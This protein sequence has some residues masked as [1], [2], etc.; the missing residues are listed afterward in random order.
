MSLVLLGDGRY[1]EQVADVAAALTDG[2][3]GQL[4]V[5]SDRWGDEDALT[6]RDDIKRVESLI[7]AVHLGL[8][9]GALESPAAR[10]QIVEHAV[11]EGAEV[12][13]ALVHPDAR[14]GA[15]VELGAGS[16]V[17][18]GAS[19]GSGVRV[20]DHAHIGLD[21]FVGDESVVG[22][23]ATVGAG[24]S[25]GRGVGIDEGATIGATVTVL[26]GVIIG[27]GAIV[28]DGAVVTADVAPASTVGR[29]VPLR[30]ARPQVGATVGVGLTRRRMGRLRSKRRVMVF[31]QFALPR[32]AP[33]G[34]RHVELFERLT[35]WEATIIAG[36]KSLLE[37]AP[38]VAEGSLRTVAV[39]RYRG[40]GLSRI[41]NWASYSAQAVWRGLTCRRPHVVYGSSPHLGAALAGLIVARARRAKF[42]LEVRDLWPQILVDAGMMKET[43][44]LYRLLKQLERFLYRHADGVVVLAR[45][46]VDAVIAEGADPQRVFFVPNGADPEDF[47][48]SEWREDLRDEFAF[49]GTVVVYAGAHGPANGLDLVLD[50]AEKLTDTDVEFVLVGDGVSKADLQA[51][52]QRRGITNVRF[53]DPIPKSEI[54]RL[55]AAA[56]VGLHCLADVALFHHGVS[57]N[58]LYDYMAAG[59]PV[60]TNTPGEV[61]S[62]VIEADSG[63]AVGPRELADG[64]RRLADLSPSVRAKLGR[65]GRE[66]MAENRSRRS[67]AVQLE[68]ILSSL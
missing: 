28:A 6:Q 60:V 43:A 39:T 24:A 7:A 42:V 61:A 51:D 57:P 19:L 23:Y 35:G 12:A 45:G 30:H 10:R 50:A 36:D 25:I 58:K 63:E 4:Y 38:V 2:S 52:A 11:D 34:T 27:R 65:S 8:V 68:G 59:L 32:S 26:D 54:A 49:D 37:Q 13:G 17:M 33:G 5:A 29:S 48:V 67:L 64:I 1:V 56:D 15:D 3:V 44:A 40:N 22:L 55:F 31:N 18:A 46:C 9:V 20:G 47:D 62:M 14:L 16:V 53:L 66:W 21:A 41:V